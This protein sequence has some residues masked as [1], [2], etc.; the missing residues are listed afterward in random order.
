PIVPSPITATRIGASL[1]KRGQTPNG[2]R[3]SVVTPHVSTAGRLPA[4]PGSIATVVPA[5]AASDADRG[6]TRRHPAHR[7][8]SKAGCRTAFPG[9]VVDK[10]RAGH[11]VSAPNSS[12]LHVTVVTHRGWT[13]VVS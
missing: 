7:A 13:W 8:H 9:G 5:G 11:P 2:S 10:P 1:P 4:D 3:G 6:V 12:W